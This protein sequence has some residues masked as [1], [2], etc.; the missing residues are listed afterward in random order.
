MFD[1][2]FK[3]LTDPADAIEAQG[4]LRKEVRIEP[5]KEKPKLIGGAVVDI[6]MYEMEGFAAVN[7]LSYLT[8]ETL[9]EVVVKQETTF[10]Y[11]PA[12]TSFREVPMLLSAWE[13]LKIKPDVLIVEG[14]GIAHPR[15]FGTA[16]HIGI[17]LDIPTIGCSRTVV[18]G[19]FEEVGEEVGSVAYMYDPF[20]PDQVVGAVM[21]TKRGVA[22]IYISVGHK[23]T[24]DE[25]IEI[26]RR[27]TFHH[28]MPENLHRAYALAVAQRTKNV[29]GH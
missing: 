11:L 25:A 14:E 5:L 20:N 21:R 19:M 22:P 17:T 15:N 24:I 9:E 7:T 3:F 16:C 4:T 6:K 28:R 2:L 23:I 13:K 26:V 29:L 10:P 18:T 8:L 12:M 1:K 27:S